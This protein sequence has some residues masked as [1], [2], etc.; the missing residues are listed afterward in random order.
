M[1]ARCGFST[2]KIPMEESSPS[3][4]TP[5]I[6]AWQRA[7]EREL[8]EPRRPSGQ[9]SGLVRAPQDPPFFGY[10]SSGGAVR[11][12]PGVTGKVVDLGVANNAKLGGGGTMLSD[13]ELM[14]RYQEGDRTAFAEIFRRYAPL[15]LRVMK[16]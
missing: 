16:Q 4:R 13:E 11:K 8:S 14:D 1:V 3:S 5:A 2:S 12:R 7:P 10:A 6:L 9:Q 15:L